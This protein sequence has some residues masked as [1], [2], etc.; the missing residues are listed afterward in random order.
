MKRSLHLLKKSLILW[1]KTIKKFEGIKNIVSRLKNS[2]NTAVS[3]Y[4]DNPSKFHYSLLNVIHSIIMCE[5]DSE[6][7]EQMSSIFKLFE[8]SGQIPHTRH[9]NPQ[10]QNQQP[11]PSIF[12]TNNSYL[13]HLFSLIMKRL[14]E[15]ALKFPESPESAKL[16]QEVHNYIR[17]GFEHYIFTLNK[18][19]S[20]TQPP[21]SRPMNISPGTAPQA[22]KV[23]I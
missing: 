8:M 19:K 9:S 1:P 13:L 22:K 21:P 18:A 23:E 4:G 15:V 12:T 17:D 14:L 20:A 6:I 11:G 3:H 2:P 16:L 5:D 7:L 10:M